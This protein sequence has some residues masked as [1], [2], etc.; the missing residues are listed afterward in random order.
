MNKDPR[1]PNELTTLSKITNDLTKD[2][3]TENFLMTDEGLKAPSKNKVFNEEDVKIVKHCRFEGETDPA[4]MSIV[5]AV[6]TNDGVKGIIVAG[7][8]P[9]ADTQLM[10]FIK[11]VEELPNSNNPAGK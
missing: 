5:Y 7:Y 8:G 3:F 11:N 10:E 4:D 2:G 6:K 1:Q 9:N